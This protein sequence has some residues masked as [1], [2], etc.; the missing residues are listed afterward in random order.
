[1]TLREVAEEM[2]AMASVTDIDAL[3]WSAAI[4]A[5]EQEDRLRTSPLP[6][7]QQTRLPGW[8]DPEDQFWKIGSA[9]R[10]R[11]GD[12]SADDHLTHVQLGE[13]NFR[14]VDDAMRRTRDDYFRLA[15][16]YASGCASVSDAVLAWQRDQRGAATP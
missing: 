16:Y 15:P 10:V 6:S 5:A 2:I 9:Q 8:P 4:A 1:M 3:K 11:V 14:A 7:S 12:A 13:E